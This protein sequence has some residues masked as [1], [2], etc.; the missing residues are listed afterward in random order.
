MTTDRMSEE[1]NEKNSLIYRSILRDMSEGVLTIGMDG[2]IAGLNPAAEKILEKTS[3]ELAGKTF[4]AAFLEYEQNDEFNQLI[5][6]SIY[7]A[8]VTHEGIVRFFTGNTEKQLHVT[9]SYLHDEGKR[10]AVIVVLRD[11]TELTE[12]RDAVKAMERICIL[13]DKLEKRNK[14]LSETFGRYLSDE[15]VNRLL[16]TPDGLLMGGKKDRITVLMSDLR[17]FTA[18][19]EKVPAQELVTML[20]HYL[21]EMTE[22]IEKR[23]GT[24]IEFIGDGILAIFGAP[25]ELK[26]HAD[27]AVAAA[28]EMEQRMEDINRWNYEQ[29]YPVLQMGIGINT[30]EVI[31][32]NIGSVK[33][34]KYGVV[35][36]LINLCGRI[37][38]Y[39]TGGQIMIGP[40][41]RRELVAEPEVEE[42]IV[43]LPKGVKSQITLSRITGLGAPYNLSY[44]HN[45][46]ILTYLENPMEIKYRLI[47][48]KHAGDKLFAGKITA[49]AS[50]CACMETEEDIK[51]FDNIVIEQEEKV[52]AK[53]I[54]KSERGLVIRYTSGEL[55]F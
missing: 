23:N 20:N 14:L 4:A 44:R 40:D 36:S 30:G 1:K 17:G 28:L 46:E 10:V 18:M 32:G 5:L 43:V 48:E 47:T 34:T 50:D 15:I 9:T 19:C 33:R 49:Y 45:D 26:C 25:V 35:G 42:E 2:R 3:P 24:I 39:T 53:I 37:E 11:I 6:D 27:D 52:F 41:T 8:D 38:S 31:V 16:E 12:L 55:V 13:N 54:G 22:I 7:E 51:V 21:G 29:G